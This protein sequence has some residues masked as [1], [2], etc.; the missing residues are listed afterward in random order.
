MT[1]FGIKHRLAPWLV[2]LCCLSGMVQ[3]DWW[4][5]NGEEE[6]PQ[7]QVQVAEPFVAL[8]SG[9]GAMYP[10]IHTSER[11]EWLT[12][13][14]RKTTWIKVSDDKGREGWVHVNDIQRAKDGRGRLVQ[15]DAPRFDDFK[16]RRWESGLM[17]G[18]FDSTAVN[19]AYAGYWL[20][21]HIS[22]ELW[23]SQILGTASEI[24][25]FNLNLLHQ[26]FSNWRVSPFFTL[27][28]GH[29]FI[30]PKATLAQ[31]EDRDDSTANVG[32]GLRYYVSDRY[33][34]R[35]EVKDYKVFTSR[36]SNEEATEWKLGLSVFF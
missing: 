1:V 31:S 35:M 30:K 18:E 24:R 3:A 9:P 33:F 22:A 19:A 15:L 25:M 14:I 5:Q 7:P 21:E 29:M 6:P 32:L 28:F 13:H 16:T 12:L 8:R 36:E 2:L 20:T 34:L 23:G 27:G 26:P 4:W 10:V 17:M 11:G